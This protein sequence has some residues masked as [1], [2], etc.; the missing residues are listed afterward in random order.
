[1]SK[2]RSTVVLMMMLATGPA[3]AR[4]DDTVTL[5]LAGLAI[6]LPHKDGVDYVVSGSW[7]TDGSSFEG[8]DAID[9]VRDGRSMSTTWASIGWFEDGG[10]L[11]L[12]RLAPID[13]AWEFPRLA[14]WGARWTARGGIYRGGGEMDGRPIVTLCVERGERKQLVLSRFALDLATTATRTQLL[15]DARKSEVLRRVYRSFAG[16][17]TVASAPAREAR[18]R[19]TIAA[20][21]EVTML[22]SEVT[23]TLPDDG[24]IWIA[25]ADLSGI[26]RFERMAPALPELS[27]AVARVDAPFTC[28]EA[29]ALVGGEALAKPATSLPTGWLAGPTSTGPTHRSLSACRAF[30]WGVLVVGVVSASKAFDYGPVA[31]LLE[32]IAHG[33]DVAERSAKP[34][35][36]L[37]AELLARAT[38]PRGHSVETR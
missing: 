3:A 36:T 37:A 18:N 9:E 15:R 21:R 33:A 22:W 23:F 7:R 20:A 17:R 32:A 8:G 1:M 5:T 14:L 11:D 19:G 31:P 24:S 29:L 28:G 6:D 4:A 25:G 16:D 35:V 38:R 26:D 30:K 2:G 27:T 13:D 34:A 10:C 12:L